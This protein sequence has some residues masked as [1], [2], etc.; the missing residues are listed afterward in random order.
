MVSETAAQGEAKVPWLGNL[1]DGWGT[2]SSKWL[3]RPS[4][5]LA[6]ADDI[7]L[8]ATQAYGVI[9]QARYQEMIGRKITQLTKHQEKRKHVEPDDFVISMRSFQGGLERAWE[10][11]AIRSSYVV[12]KPTERVHVPFFAHLFKSH[13]YIKALQATANFIRDGQDL[14]F[15]NFKMVDLPLVPLEEQ[16]LLARYLD[17][18]DR[19]I[20]R[21][22]RAKQKLIRLLEEQKQVIVNRAVTRGLDPDVRFK[23]S[24]VEW[25]GDVPE[26]WGLLKLKFLCRLGTGGKDTVDQVEGGA[27]PFFVRSQTVERI[28]SFTYDGEAVL[29]AGDGAGVAKVF[30]YFKG[31]F[32]YHQRVYA[33]T[34][35]RHVSG[36]YFYNYL[37]STLKYEALSGNAKSTVDSLRRPL[38][39]N[40]PVPIPPPD[41]QDQ[42]VAWIGSQTAELESAIA[43]AKHEIQLLGE[44]RTRL[45]AD[46]VTGKLDVREAA[47]QLP[48]EDPAIDDDTPL[49]PDEAA[50]LDEA[51]DEM[52]EVDA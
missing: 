21:Y 49:K 45:I 31:K 8:S 2:I 7:Q 17:H 11:G 28:D 36:I 18:V 44:Y 33:F 10:R 50:D 15:D 25:L 52:E 26:H 41:E 47:A 19:R 32:D 42:L 46:V 13:D 40:F 43:L 48:D 3:F 27:Y 16:R 4:K 20:R 35:F 1:P 34:N 9:S 12:L 14:N 39:A 29:T 22:I 5:E 30:H 37:K 23:P 51:L 24:G 38:L 6:R